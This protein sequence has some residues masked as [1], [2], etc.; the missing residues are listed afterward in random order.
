[1]RGDDL[2]SRWKR[3]VRNRILP[4]FFVALSVSLL[5]IVFGAVR[6]ELS[7]GIGSS[8]VLFASVAASAFILFI[9]PLST[10][11]NPLKFIKSYII[12]GVVGAASYYLLA[13]L[14]EYLVVG[15]VIF[16][17]SA[18][19]IATRSEHAPALGI[20]FTFVLFRIDALGILVVIIAAAMLLVLR[21]LADRLR[22]EEVEG[23]EERAE[24]RHRRKR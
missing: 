1:M 3:H 15:T 18:L 17:V 20:A 21:A 14:P 24:A 23:K 4:V 2:H 22:V 16:V 7:Y 6:F 19:L 9:M 12:A 13:F 5:V 10:M 8:A 11:A